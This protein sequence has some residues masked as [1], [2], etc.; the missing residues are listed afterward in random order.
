MKAYAYID[1]ISLDALIPIDQP[2]PEPGDDE[3]VVAM[4]AV[5]L[6]YRDLAIADGDYHVQVKPPLIPMSDGAGEVVAAGKAVKRFRIGDKVCAVYLPDW[7]KGT[8]SREAAARRLGG[9][10]N[11]VLRELMCASEQ[12][13]VRAPGHLSYE[14]AATLPVASVTAWQTLFVNGTVRPGDNVL[15]QGSGGV[16]IAA[17]QLARAAGARVISVTR[18]DDA[19]GELRTLGTS[20]VVVSR[21]NPSWPREVLELTGGAGADVIVNVAGG[22]TVGDCLAAAG[23]G[24]TV[25]LVGYS[26]GRDV[27]FD[28]FDAI[29]RAARFTVATA[30][31]RD[32]FERLVQ[33]LELQNVRPPI[34]ERHPVAS[35]RLALESLRKGGHIGKVVL[36]F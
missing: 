12:D 6:N 29:R 33:T 22:K 9:P 30:G 4:K 15:V 14:E 13:F 34:A 11:G 1:R 35:Y 16:S 7:K 5:S 28:M 18:T 32:S 19:R 25:H 2:D 36:S 8:L 3:I 27:S 23:L 21:G 20:E 26:S 24:A 31:S 10:S 17:M